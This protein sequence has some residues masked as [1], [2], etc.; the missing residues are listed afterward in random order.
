MT[1]LPGAADEAAAIHAEFAVEV[2]YAAAALRPDGIVPAVRTQAGAPVFGDVQSVRQRAY[3][4]QM[5]DLTRRPIDGDTVT[6]AGTD[7]RVIDVIDRDDVDAWVV[8][9]EAA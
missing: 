2:V 9:V 1:D 4:L 3:E 8:M 7:Y 5:A 6:D